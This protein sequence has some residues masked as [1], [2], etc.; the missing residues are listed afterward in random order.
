MWYSIRNGIFGIFINGVLKMMI[1]NLN[2]I[3]GDNVNSIK[4]W[5][6]I[7]VFFIKYSWFFIKI[8]YLQRG[9][10]IYNFFT[11]L[12][13]IDKYRFFWKIQVGHEFLK[14]KSVS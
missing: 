1:G 3:N 10:N 7:R 4:P 6:P 13:W 9:D 2:M 5:R 8:H 11:I 14:F 12:N